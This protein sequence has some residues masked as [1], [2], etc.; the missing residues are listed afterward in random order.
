MPSRGTVYSMLGPDDAIRGSEITGI[1]VGGATTGGTLRG[2]R[3]ETTKP[4][5][6]ATPATTASAGIHLLIVSQVSRGSPQPRLA[7]AGMTA[8][9]DRMPHPTMLLPL[10]WPGFLLVRPGREPRLHLMSPSK[11]R[12]AQA[13]IRRCTQRWPP[14]LPC[15]ASAN[16]VWKIEEIV[17]LPNARIGPR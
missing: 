15:H 3:A 5:T 12:F 16:R 1:D 13:T 4:I 14:T 11:R 2:G 6:P 10:F 9:S 8:E 17:P 7:L